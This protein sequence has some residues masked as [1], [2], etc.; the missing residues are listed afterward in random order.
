MAERIITPQ[1]RGFLLFD[2][3]PAGCA[4]TIADMQDQVQP[5][6]RPDGTGP[7]PVALVVGC[8]AGYGMAMTVAGIARHGISGVGVCLERQ[9]T[10]RRTATA[11]WY[12]VGAAAKLAAQAGSDF[13]FI[14][15]D[16]FA[17]ATKDQALGLIADRFGR[18]DYLIYSVAAP[19]R[20][21]AATGATYQ[22]VIQPLGSA[23]RTRTLSFDGGSPRLRDVTVEPASAQ[24]AAD[25]I[26]VMGGED[27]ALWVRAARA[28]GLTGPGFAT[29]ALSYIGSEL[30]SAIYRDGTIGA[31]KEHLEGTAVELDSWLREQ[32]GRAVTSV[33]G[34]A[35]TQ[36][37]TAIPGI[38][39]YLSL[40]REVLDG[41]MVAPAAQAASLWDQLTGLVPADVDEH[42]RIRLDRWELDP[43]VQQEV[44]SR[45]A[46]CDAGSLADLADA[47]W[48]RAEVMRLYGFEV[49]GVDYGLPCEPDLPWPGGPAVA[50]PG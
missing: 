36:S 5:A 37:S 32:G 29:A 41:R 38:A 39:L 26:K 27:W 16:A 2:A 13:S 11:G 24:Q 22:S 43:A 45:W 3:H 6:P 19:R 40:L 33:N 50:G 25:T 35:V 44:A 23:C 9:P 8:S 15:A 7:R 30:T 17:D 28:S 14:N 31:A 18:L 1:G 47:G 4:R 46:A 34:A 20:A 42:G 12:R 21:D 10:H 48:F 49:A